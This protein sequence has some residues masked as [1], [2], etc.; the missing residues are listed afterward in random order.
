MIQDDNFQ[1]I[2]S[3]LKESTPLTLGS[4]G[5]TKKRGESNAMKKHVEVDYTE[6]MVDYWKER[7]VSYSQQNRAQIEGFKREIWEGL[8]LSNAPQKKKLRILDIGTGPGFF[9]II[10]AQK[11]HQVTAVDISADML[12]QAK[13]NARHYG[14]DVQFQLLNAQN[15]P[16]SDNAFDLVISRD[17][18]WTL[19]EPEEM[20]Q[21]WNRVT[22]PGGR[23]LY[24]DANWY[25]YLYN[26]D[27]LRAHEENVRICQEQGGFSYT[28]A[29]VME[30][31]ALG[32]P[33]SSRL[34]PAWDL[35]E[36]PRLGFRKV[37]ALENL[38]PWIYTE[39][40]CMQYRSK[41]E[42]LVIAEK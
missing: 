25:H 16:F 15:L 12:E 7:S 20:L 3:L 26:E 2:I 8:I 18:T 32:L 24:F 39:Q 23:V 21:E 13:E 19:Q 30:E 17:V 42:F 28:K 35:Q 14:A 11:G 37:T 5:S 29:N 34:R 9:A 36:L 1:K 4:V 27:F 22:K 33:M 6:E 41:P 10:L 31:I 40:E 38:N